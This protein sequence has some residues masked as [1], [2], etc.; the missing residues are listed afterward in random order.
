MPDSLQNIDESFNFYVIG[1]GEVK[2]FKDYTQD[3]R[4]L[5]CLVIQFNHQY[6]L[7]RKKPIGHHNEASFPMFLPF[8]FVIQVKIWCRIYPPVSVN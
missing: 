8:D 6:I 1:V 4:T 3:S 5:D 7:S 2:W